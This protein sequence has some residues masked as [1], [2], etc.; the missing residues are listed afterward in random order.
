MKNNWAHWQKVKTQEVEVGQ[1]QVL[2]EFTVPVIASNILLQF[3]TG[4]TAKLMHQ[5][6][7]REARQNK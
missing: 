4:L 6:E 1:K 5:K 2:I 7:G 3:I